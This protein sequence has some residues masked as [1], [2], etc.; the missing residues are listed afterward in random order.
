ML[1]KIIYC[2]QCSSQ[3]SI[4]DKYCYD[5]GAPNKYNNFR[6]NQERANKISREI[7]SANNKGLR[8]GVYRKDVNRAAFAQIIIENIAYISNIKN[9]YLTNAEF[10]LILKLT[11]ITEK[12]SNKLIKLESKTTYGFYNT[13]QNANISWITN[14]FNFSSRSYVSKIMNS[15]LEKGILIEKRTIPN[16]EERIQKARPLFFNPEIVYRG[17]KNKISGELCKM[18]LDNDILEKKNIKIPWKIWISK[19]EKNGRLYKRNTYNRKKS[20][21]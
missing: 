3:I 17:D 2:T 14:F 4:E 21:N 16:S 10:A 13:K 15:L 8:V 9:N 19:R 12:H 6:S 20:N 18:V 5:C 7:N 11:T 1:N